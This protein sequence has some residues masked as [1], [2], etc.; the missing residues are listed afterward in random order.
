[1]N[2]FKKRGCKRD[3]STNMREQKFS[4][5]KFVGKIRKKGKAVV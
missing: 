3:L 1:M 5:I 2:K 4:M